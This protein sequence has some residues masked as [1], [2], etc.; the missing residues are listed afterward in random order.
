SRTAWIPVIQ[1]IGPPGY[2]RGPERQNMPPRRGAQCAFSTDSVTI[3]KNSNWP[4][5]STTPRHLQLRS[6]AH[7]YSWIKKTRLASDRNRGNICTAKTGPREMRKARGIRTRGH[8]FVCFSACVV[9]WVDSNAYFSGRNNG[10]RH[11]HNGY[12]RNERAGTVECHPGF[13]R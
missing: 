7:S 13:V 2:R 6:D 3:Q 1:F 9:R 8:A 10:K 11:K 4:V 12:G 5:T